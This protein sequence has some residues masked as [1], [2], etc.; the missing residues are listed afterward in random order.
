MS[1]VWK[2]HATVAAVIHR[3]GKFLLVREK[4]EGRVVLNQPAGHLEDKETLIEAVEREVAEETA[5]K[6]QPTGV[7]GI[8]LWRHPRYGHTHMRTTFVGDVS[9]HNP[10]QKLDAPII[11]AAWYTRDELTKNRR[12]LRSN[13][14][15]A[16][17]DDFLTAAC[18]PLD[19]LRS[20]AS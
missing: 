18:Y 5:W 16:R 13:L 6:F 3:D 11:D 7:L 10:K 4:I 8:Y 15:L 2:P 1:G 19:M 14:V 20:V 9:D 12:D 17:I